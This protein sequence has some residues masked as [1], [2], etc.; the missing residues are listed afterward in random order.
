MHNLNRLVVNEWLKLFKKRSFFVP[1]A[2]LIGVSLLASYMIHSFAEGMFG[3]V[4][5]FMGTM[6][7]PKGMGQIITIM[8]IIGSSGIVAKEYSQ[9]TIKFLLI[10]ARSR[11]A[12]LTSKY[13]TAL[14][15]GLSLTLAT[16]VA[17]FV[18][19]SIWFGFSGAE[20]R[21]LDVLGS[22]GYSYIYTVV[23]ITLAFMIGILT[24]SGGATIG[25]TMLMLMLD[26]TII[27]KGFYKYLLFPNLDLSVYTDGGAPLP[28]MTLS[29]SIVMLAVYVLLFLLA[30]FVVFRRRDVA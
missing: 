1:Y 10:R 30:G 6:L 19:G 7:Y 17:L 8:A 22:L 14:I 29:F 9:G 16:A 5:D 12:I 21:W 13:I 11:S 2:L 26:K 27:Q 23:Y 24:T 25:I 3:S 20:E 4:Y 18:S 15:Y 28:G